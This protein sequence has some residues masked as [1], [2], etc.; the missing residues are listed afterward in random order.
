MVVHCVSV[1]SFE[2]YLPH[3]K[4]DCSIFDENK[5]EQKISCIFYF[6][7]FLL[8]FRGE[9]LVKSRIRQQ[10]DFATKIISKKEI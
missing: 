6:S 3:S 9:N 8:N 10:K 5:I 4:Y 2:H 7:R 1:H